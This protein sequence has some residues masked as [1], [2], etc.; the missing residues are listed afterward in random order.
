MY[1]VTACQTLYTMVCV[2]LFDL[3]NSAYLRHLLLTITRWEIRNRFPYFVDT[4]VKSRPNDEIKMMTAMPFHGTG[5]IIA[6]VLMIY[7]IWFI[8]LKNLYN[9]EYGSKS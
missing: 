3:P 5:G 8:K 2:D 7:A 6:V 4:E 9:A 1:H